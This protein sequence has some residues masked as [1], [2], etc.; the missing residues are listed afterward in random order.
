[1][2]H[3]T[4]ARVLAALGALVLLAPLGCETPTEAAAADQLD[5]SGPPPE[6]YATWDEYWKGKDREYR[7][8]EH[9]V[10]GLEMSRQRTPGAPR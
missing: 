4:T 6:G 3:R 9:D 1:M 7:D 5:T 8:F 10:R 2:R